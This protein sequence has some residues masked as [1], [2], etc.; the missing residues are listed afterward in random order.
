MS[1]SEAASTRRLGP[2]VAGLA[3]APGITREARASGGGPSPPRL[4]AWAVSFALHAA[5]FLLIGLTVQSGALVRVEPEPEER[6]VFIE[7]APPPPPPLSREG[8]VATPQS[9]DA[10]LAAPEA[11]SAKPTRYWNHRRIET[12]GSRRPRSVAL[13]ASS[14]RPRAERRP[15]AG[16]ERPPVAHNDALTSREGQLS[17]LAGGV[18][19]G[20]EGG[21]PGGIVGGRGDAPVPV[22]LAGRSPILR[23]RVL[24]TYPEA[25]RLRGREGQVVLRAVIDRSGRVE[26]EITVVRSDPDFDAAAIAAFRQWLFDPARDREGRPIRVVLTVPLRFQIR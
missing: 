24:P 23:S 4:I 6:L 21:K 3:D 9:G 10:T 19:G 8:R 22:E 26:S 14:C 13:L 25:A 18:E 20:E 1:R 17:G 5:V 12:S 16:R 7:P 11:E 2:L 15:S